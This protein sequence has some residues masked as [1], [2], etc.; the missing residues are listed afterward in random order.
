ME[1]LCEER[2]W[3]GPYIERDLCSQLRLAA[4]VRHDVNYVRMVKAANR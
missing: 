2:L 4:P 1:S 3:S